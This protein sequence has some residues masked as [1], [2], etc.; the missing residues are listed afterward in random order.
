MAKWPRVSQRLDKI[1]STIALDSILTTSAAFAQRLVA[2]PAAR[3]RTCPTFPPVC[4]EFAEQ[5]SSEKIS[6]CELNFRF[7]LA[8][9]PKTEIG[10]WIHCNSYA[11]PTMKKQLPIV[12][13]KKLLLL[14]SFLDDGFQSGNTTVPEVNHHRTSRFIALKEIP[15]SAEQFAGN[16]NLIAIGRDNQIR[17]HVVLKRY[18]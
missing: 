13:T 9:T 15:E 2:L 4:K 17:L 18:E 5:H 12:K 14:I 10:A 8:R 11:T 6:S 3:T 7:V 16:L 1:A